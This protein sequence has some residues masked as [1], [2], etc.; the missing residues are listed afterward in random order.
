MKAMQLI[1]PQIDAIRN[2]YRDNPQKMNKE[3]FDVYKR[4]NINPLSGCL[5]ILLQMPVFIALYPVLMRSNDLSSPDRIAFL[6]FSLPVLGN[7]INVLPL[8]MAAGMFLQQKITSKAAS[9]PQLAEQQRIMMFMFPIMFG[10]IFYR[11][12]AGL[13]LYWL[14]NSVIML[15][16]QFNV[17]R[18]R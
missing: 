3:I 17:H 11:M 15:L 8:L 14:V 12:P 4:H 1:Q 7:E 6:P 10:L 16:F 18:D 13:V 5:P 2:T 9:S